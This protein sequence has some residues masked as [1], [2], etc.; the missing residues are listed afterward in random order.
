MCMYIFNAYEVKINYMY[1]NMF[2]LSQSFQHST[3]RYK[4]NEK[5][6][7][8]PK[9]RSWKKDGTCGLATL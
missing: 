2:P 4:I 8:K 5:G 1:I 6:K 9:T 3:H 7:A